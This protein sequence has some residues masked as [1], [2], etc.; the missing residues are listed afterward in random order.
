ML[1]GFLIQSLHM[2]IHFIVNKQELIPVSQLLAVQGY[3]HQ[4][5]Y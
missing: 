3:K 1:A 4:Y 2:R 5:C